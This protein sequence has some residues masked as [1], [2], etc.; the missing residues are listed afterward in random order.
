MSHMHVVSITLEGK[1][2][3]LEPLQLKHATDLYAA[4][5]E[6][7]IWRYMSTN[8]G[9]SLAAMAQWIETAQQAQVAG[10]ELPFAIVSRETDKAVG[11]TRY[12]NIIPKDRG[13]EIGWTW[14]TPGVQR[15]GIN[16]E[17]KYLLLRHAFETLGAIRVQLKTDSRNEQSQRAIERIGGVKE[18]ILRNH[19]IMPDGYLRHSVYYSVIDSEWPSVKTRLEQMMQ[20]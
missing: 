1:V 3:R 19:V 18:G 20:R 17:C 15:T 7:R 16:T 5:Q 12:L 13:L 6:A 2:A 8:P 14:L 10:H 9:V 11:S 4:G